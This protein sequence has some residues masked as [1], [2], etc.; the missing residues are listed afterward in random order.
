M[1]KRFSKIRNEVSIFAYQL[2]ST[3]CFSWQGVYC[4]IL[5]LKGV[6]RRDAG[7]A[8]AVK[9]LYGTCIVPYDSVISVLRY[10]DEL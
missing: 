9:C 8:V 6:C 7:L 2:R 1:I 5:N 3:D 10:A 4:P